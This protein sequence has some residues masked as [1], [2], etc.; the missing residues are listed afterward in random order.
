[1]K[2]ARSGE[3][4]LCILKQKSICKNSKNKLEQQEEKRKIL[5]YCLI[6]ITNNLLYYGT[7]HLE[8]GTIN[9]T[10]ISNI[11]IGTK[12]IKVSNNRLK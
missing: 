2:K 8:S 6:N 4:C 10:A 11:K 12:P 7:E 3:T 5:S 1:M 9:K